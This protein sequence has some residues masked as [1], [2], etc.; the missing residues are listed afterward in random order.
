MITDIEQRSQI[1][2]DLRVEKLDSYWQEYFTFRDEVYELHQVVERELIDELD[3]ARSQVRPFLDAQQRISIIL[4]RLGST[5]NFHR[6]FSEQ[7]PEFKP[8]Q[9][10]GMQL[11][12]LVVSDSET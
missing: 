1:G 12:A 11:Y 2:P 4:T 9:I 3:K 6:Q 7:F 10:I 5:A 8:N